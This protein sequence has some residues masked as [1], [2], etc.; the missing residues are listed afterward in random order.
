MFLKLLSSEEQQEYFL[1][2]AYLVA[3]SDGEERN[4]E[5]RNKDDQNIGYSFFTPP[6]ELGNLFTSAT[7]LDKQKTRLDVSEINMMKL[8]MFEMD[9]PE[10]IDDLSS[11]EN[12]RLDDLNEW[13]EESRKEVTQESN[14]KKL[15]MISLAEKDFDITALDKDEIEKE[16][17][18][19][20]VT[21]NSIFSLAGNSAAQKANVGFNISQIKAVIFELVGMAYA[22]GEFS[23]IELETVKSISEGFG[24]DGETFEDICS[25]VKKL[26][27]V[28]AEASEIIQE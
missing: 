12:N 8:F 21:R 11:F 3:L 16:F 5:E 28:A 13:I 22:D 7:E 4:V 1:N 9:Y 6:T 14:A 27:Q 18:N 26:S 17:M 2:L 24:V 23:D 20:A 15:V 10:F 25:Y 19:N